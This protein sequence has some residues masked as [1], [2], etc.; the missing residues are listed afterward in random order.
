MTKK[1]LSKIEKLATCTADEAV[2]SGKLG[3][4]I[5]ALKVLSPIYT[6]LKKEQGRYRDPDDDTTMAGLQAELE[7]AENGSEVQRHRGRRADA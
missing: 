2:S 3:E 7:K 6:L 5:E 1:I 4:K